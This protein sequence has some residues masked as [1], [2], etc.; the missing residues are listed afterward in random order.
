MRRLA[1][2]LAVTIAL[3]GVVVVASEKRAFAGC[4]TDPVTGDTTCWLTS[5]PLPASSVTVGDGRTSSFLWTQV[6]FDSPFADDFPALRA[7]PGDCT[8]QSVDGDTT[9]IEVGNVYLVSLKNVA[10]GDYVSAPTMTCVFPGDPVP[11]P[12]PPPP[13][14]AELVEAA[15]SAATVAPSLNPRVEIG[16]LTGLDTWLWCDAPA[17]V[18][19]GVELRGWSA[20]ATLD[21]VR[22][23]WAITGTDTASFTAK[24]CGSEAAPAA[25]WMP[26]RKGP[27]AVTLTATWAGSWELAYNGAPAGVFPLGPFDFVAPAVSYPVDEYRGVLTPP[28]SVER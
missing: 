10:T 12:P 23:R 18:D 14:E 5:P 3:A 26:Q 4:R 1:N 28:S 25:T 22:Y 20:S 21:V 27:Y 9:T 6:A 16:G 17:S 15:R 8:R 19:V 2:G 13:S 7:A 11:Q 24:T